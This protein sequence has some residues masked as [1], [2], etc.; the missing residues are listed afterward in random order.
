MSQRKLPDERVAAIAP[1]GLRMPPGLR[2]RIAQAAEKEGR[3]MNALIVRVLEDA[4]PPEPTLDDMLAELGYLLDAQSVNM[5]QQFERSL[6][7]Q[8]ERLKLKI[9]ATRKR[10]GPSSSDDPP[11]QA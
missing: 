3:S 2:E 1:F 6:M 9:S 5:D 11:P 7:R 10:L 4:F 8:I